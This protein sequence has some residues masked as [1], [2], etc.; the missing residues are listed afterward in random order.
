MQED[1]II[2]GC[3]SGQRK[4]QSELYSFYASKFYGICLRYASSQSEAEDLLQEGFIKIFTAL[5]TYRAEGS[6]EGWMKRIVVNNALN[7]IRLNSK[8]LSTTSF[9]MADSDNF[10]DP[11]EDNCPLEPVSLETLLKL[12][13]SL[14]DGYRMVF[15]LY[16]FENYTH[17]QIAEIAGF[18]ESTS[19]TQ[20]MRARNLLQ[21]KI[22]GI[23]QHAILQS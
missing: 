8:Q 11:D 20:L 9:D 10:S 15:N 18:S 22:S 1:K 23:S 7:H 4:A 17:K 2:S 5:K 3:I 13:Q 19:K 14:P 6:F 12:V 21:K 16:V